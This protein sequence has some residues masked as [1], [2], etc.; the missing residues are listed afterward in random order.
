MTTNDIYNWLKDHAVVHTG[1]G[2]TYDVV[3][4]KE[5][6]SLIEFLMEERDYWKNAYMEATSAP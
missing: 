6:I 3:R 5:A 2:D 4:F 1:S